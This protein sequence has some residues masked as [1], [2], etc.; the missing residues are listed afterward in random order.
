MLRNRIR[1]NFWWVSLF[2][3]AYPTR[4]AFTQ[5][6]PKWTAMRELRIDG[7]AQNLVPV[8]RLAVD[9]SGRIYAM[10]LQ[11]LNIRVFKADGT[12]E[13]TIGRK[14]NGPGEFR[15]LG[16]MGLFGDT[17]W[18]WDAELERVS[19]FGT[20]SK[21]LHTYRIKGPVIRKVERPMLAYA[22]HRSGSIVALIGDRVSPV[23]P[24][25]WIF[26]RSNKDGEV[27]QTFARRSS[28]RNPLSFSNYDGGAWYFSLDPNPPMYGASDNGERIGVATTALSGDDAG[29]GTFIMRNFHGDTLYTRRFPVTLKPIPVV[30]LDSA[31]AA[32]RK[33]PNT[34]ASFEAL[35]LPEFYPPLEY[36]RIARNGSALLAFYAHSPERDFLM[37]NSQ[38]NI[39]ASLVLPR[40]VIV[41]FFEGDVLWGVERDS[42][43]VESIVRYRV[44]H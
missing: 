2:L 16:A 32:I 13:R 26:G 28:H 37:I 42:N 30:V 10:Q 23:A 24:A 1:R 41:K 39:V 5:A 40:S 3:L 29:T 44:V 17:L 43:D 7:E 35:P 15:D 33:D 9:T 18:T 12:A 38:G 14:G 6:L 31:W 8:G 21:P 20:A 34:A 22:L 11:D 25:E 36:I 4:A 19:F 27:Q